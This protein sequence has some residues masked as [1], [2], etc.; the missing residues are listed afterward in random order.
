MLYTNYLW[1]KFRT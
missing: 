1:R